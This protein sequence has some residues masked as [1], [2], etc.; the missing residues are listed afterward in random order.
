ML[1]VC[2]LPKLDRA[3]QLALHQ[4]D[5]VRCVAEAL[6]STAVFS[7]SSSLGNQPLESQHWFLE[8]GFLLKIGDMKDRKASGTSSRALRAECYESLVVRLRV[9]YIYAT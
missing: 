1:Q 9:H 5:S 4:P 7:K 3:A 2:S 8:P 6:Y